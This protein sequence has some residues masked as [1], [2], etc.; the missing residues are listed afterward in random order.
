MGK[1]LFRLIYKGTYLHH[2]FR[3]GLCH[4]GNLWKAVFFPSWTWDFV[5]LPWEGL[6]L[7]DPPPAR[8]S[9]SQNSKGLHSIV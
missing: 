7:R 4:R 9:S 2:P 3:F 8:V 5:S 6:A 1:D